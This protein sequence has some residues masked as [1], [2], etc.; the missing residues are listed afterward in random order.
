M[1]DGQQPVT[2]TGRQLWHAKVNPLLDRLLKSS[3]AYRL[4]STNVSVDAAMN[5]NSGIL[6]HLKGNAREPLK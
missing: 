5:G 6:S 2:D 3:P 1:T 4:P